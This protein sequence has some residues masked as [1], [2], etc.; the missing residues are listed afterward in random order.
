VHAFDYVLH[1]VRRGKRL[2]S[3]RNLPVT[4][5]EF[6]VNDVRAVLAFGAQASRWPEPPDIYVR[7]T[8]HDLE[9]T[10]Q[11]NVLRLASMALRRGGL[12]F[13]EFR[14]TRDRG[15]RKVF[16]DHPRRYIEPTELVAAIEAAGGRVVEQVAGTGLAQFRGEDPHICRMVASWT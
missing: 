7:F 8:M 9:P 11:R 4:F 12:L 16:S 1:A 13:L 6:N 14:T 2:A 15:R 5:E 10:G 3:R